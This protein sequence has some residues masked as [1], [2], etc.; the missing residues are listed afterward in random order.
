M[1]AGEWI[2]VRTKPRRERWVTENLTRNGQEFYYP[3][4]L[5]AGRTNRP[6]IFSMFPNYLFVRMIE[7]QWGMIRSTLGVA[8]VLCCGH[9]PAIVPEPLIEDI[10]R[11]ERKGLVFL[12]TKRE[13][14]RRNDPVRINDGS[15]CGYVGL[16]QKTTG[17]QRVQILL[18]VLGCQQRVEIDR[19]LLEAA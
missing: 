14:F 1:D 2:A 3:R 10:K 17:A 4:V 8:Y 11:R 9:R 15:F 12:P 6:R 13:E 19:K 16:Y 5:D 7:G 18:N